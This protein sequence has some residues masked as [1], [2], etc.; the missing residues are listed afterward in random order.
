M[1]ISILDQLR[2]TDR[3][4]IGKSNQVVDAVLADPRLFDAVFEAMLSDDAVLRMRAADAI[5]KISAHRPDL[6]QARK[7]VILTRVAK[8]EQQEVRWHVAQIFSRLKFTARERRT[9]VEILN[10]FLQDQSG[11]VRAFSMQALADI[12]EQDEDL[13]APIITQLQT[14]TRTGTPAMKSRGKKL[15][16]KLNRAK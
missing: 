1:S 12:A 11:I 14:L 3:R 9:V 6:L 16:A 7:R 2:G 4:S 15:L 13:R 10:E 8:I 5:E